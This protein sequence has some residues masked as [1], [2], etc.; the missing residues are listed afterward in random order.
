M[1]SKRVT[2]FKRRYFDAIGSFILLILVRVA[3]K[4][5][6]IGTVMPVI[7]TSTIDELLRNVKIVDFE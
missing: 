7:I 2:L 5:L 1:S 6:Q 4:Q 3:R